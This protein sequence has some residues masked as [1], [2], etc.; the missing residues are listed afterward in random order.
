MK[1]MH[2]KRSWI[3]L[4]VLALVLVLGKT[5]VFAATE[6]SDFAGLKNAVENGGEITL[7]QNITVTETLEIKNNVTI[8]GDPKDRPKLILVKDFSEDQMFKV[9]EGKSLTLNDIIL[10]GNK[11]G[12]LINVKGG[13]VQLE[14]AILQNGS[15]EPLKPNASND[16]NYSGGAILATKNSKVIITGG[17]FLN[18]N[19]GSTPMDGNR[20]AEGGAIK[21]EDSILKINDDQ[22][23]DKKTTIF[24]GNHL[25]GWQTTGGR[26]GGSIEATR[27]KVE[28]YGATFDVPGPFNTG[29]AIKFEDCGSEK[30][31][32]K[33][34]NSSFTILGD[35]KPVGMAGG[36]ITSEGSYLTIDNSTFNTGK[37]S[38]V[39]ESGGLIQVVGKGEFHLKNST[40]NGSGV[41]WNATGANKT[42]KFGGAIVFYDDSTV[43]ATIEN[44][45]IQNFTAEISGGGIALNT[46]IGKGEKSAVNL[47]LIDTKILNNVTYAWNM[48]AYGGGIF[49]GKGNTVTMEGGQ[50]SSDQYSSVGGAIY[51]EGKLTLTK[52]NKGN[53]LIKDNKAYHMAAG[54][55]NDG[56]LK[57]DFAEFSGNKKGDGYTGEGH[58]YDENKKEL[59]GVNIYAVKDVIITPNAQFDDK[60]VRIIEK[61][62]SGETSKI[63]LTGP[64]TK[65]INVS[66][67]EKPK[68]GSNDK[69]IENQKRRIGYVVAEGTNGYAATKNDAKKLHYLSK[70]YDESKPADDANQPIAKAADDT[71][72]GMWDF[73][74]D[75]ENGKVVVGQRVKLIYHGNLGKIGSVDKE[76]KTVDVYKNPN[77]WED[78]LA[79]Y[80]VADP[81]RDKYDFMGWYYWKD[82]SEAVDTVE[83]IQDIK[84]PDG[85]KGDLFDFSRVTFENNVENTDKIITPNVI[86]TYAGWSKNIDLNVVKAW[87]DA[88]EKDKQNISV[89]LY[90]GE[91]SKETKEFD[92]STEYGGKFENLPVFTK[93]YEGEEKNMNLRFV[94]KVYKV[95]EAA[96]D[97]FTTS[98]SPESATANSDEAK[99]IKITN[100]RVKT[101]NVFVKYVTEDGTVLEA[102]SA[103]KTNALVGEAYTTT[104][105]TFEGYEFSK[106]GNSVEANGT[107]AEGEL[108]VI[109]VYKVKEQPKPKTGNVFVKYI[110]EDGKVLEEESPVLENAKVGMDYTTE[111]KTFDG[112]EYSAMG[113]GSAAASGKVVA[114]DLHVI[115]VYK[116]KTGNVF[117][118]Y[119]AEDGTEL[120]AESVVKKDA[121]VGEAYTT[122]KKAFDGYEFSKMKD[123]SA[124]TNG[125]VKE[126]DLHVIYVYK[127]VKETPKTGNVYVRHVS[128]DGLFLESDSVVKKNAPVG[129]AYTTTQKTFEC[130]KFL[131]MKDGS[132]PANGTVVEGDLYVI[133][134]YKMIEQPESETGNVYVQ[135]ITDDGKILAEESPV[136]ENAE[137]GT[138]YTTEKKAFKGYEFSKMGE[139]SAE[140]N[141]NVVAGDLHV[142]YVY[143]KT[144]SQP[145]TTKVITQYVDEN[146]NRL[147]PDRAGK[148]PVVEIKDYTYL[149]TEESD[150]LI[151][152]IY[153][154][155]QAPVHPSGSVLILPT[156]GTSEPVPDDGLL[157]KKDHKAYM[158]GY[159][160]GNFLPERNMTREEATAMF[161]RLLKDYPRERRSYN[162]PFKDVAESDWSQQ[163][164]GFMLEK[165]MIKGYED[166][167]FKP[168]AAI[169]RAEFAA[170]AARF[171]KLVAGGGNSSFDVPAGHWAQASIDSAAAKGWVT[172]YPDGSFKPERKITRAEVVNITNKMLDR[173]ADKNFVRS[174]LSEMIQFKDLTEADWAY[175]PIM[176]A[177]NGHDY[178]RKAA[179]EEN[180]IRL[181]G[182]EFRF[183]VVG[184]K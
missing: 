48:T 70:A 138:A 8:S 121:P 134:V 78:Q 169:S 47:T 150:T 112:Y 52:S 51:N 118:K 128:D 17:K 174:H 154:K 64:L 104:K 142:I 32:A 101:G 1:K 137:V 30:E 39:Q 122:E 25:D 71:S 18:N 162:I 81:A 9:P 93:T 120:E 108:H 16:Q 177:T 171:D 141:G 117:V 160:D 110:T 103:V 167:S 31:Q 107:V 90:D 147:I 46:Q 173:F 145:P 131:K 98:Y 10:D 146:G 180:W 35:K 40:L 127:K 15:T 79:D 83:T 166:G 42:A 114:G 184:R 157:N 133:Y 165:G 135:Y 84:K 87:V 102:E 22:T 126:G 124:P 77:F 113:E 59:P 143:K 149:R 5:P 89:T 12:R 153:K 21:I 151:R 111:Q 75:K 62:A 148:Q 175:F 136:L 88:E 36:A 182:E 56:Y 155:I 85:L 119:L 105:K 168:K 67:S 7:K 80:K 76:E 130:Y 123:G 132:V 99:S 152:H 73:V 115:Y 91:T 139:N 170:M 96:I 20:A 24:S 95:K 38:Y 158:F 65:Q 72:P 54:V 45:T 33:V 86:N 178:T 2:A 109:Y 29:G 60:D 183:V 129:E 61:N 63:L 55:L 37:G 66:I 68:T 97:G 163:A 34:I 125:T 100:T 181:N 92:S 28:I 41:G 26:Q 106:M 94:P 69:F 144:E 3:F 164:I 27:S 50:I 11:R 179:Q 172:G 116:A 14:N 74:L 49:V 57:V 43:K 53:A 82:E 4:M 161:A 58:V 140:P 6:V 176:E 44:T 23:T 156:P 19:T 13:T 159:P